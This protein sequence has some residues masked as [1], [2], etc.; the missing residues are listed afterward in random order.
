MVGE[1]V[2]WGV[3]WTCFSISDERMSY[4]WV[5]GLNILGG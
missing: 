2:V 5:V 1:D 4:D 3:G